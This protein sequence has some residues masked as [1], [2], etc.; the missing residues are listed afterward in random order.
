M[1]VGKYKVAKKD[2]KKCMDLPSVYGS[3]EK[4]FSLHGACFP[5]P[6]KRRTLDRN[7]VIFYADRKL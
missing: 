6:T 1:P 7:S 5:L 2:S 3:Y 4:F